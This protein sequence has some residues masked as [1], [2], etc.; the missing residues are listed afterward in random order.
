MVRSDVVRKQLAGV[1]LHDRLGPEGY[2]AEMTARTFAE[3]DRRV[4]EA[5]RIGRPVVADAVFADPSERDRLARIA[6]ACGV[7]FAVLWLEAAPARME[8]RLAA[9]IADVSDATVEVLRRQR[10]YDLGQVEWTRVDSGGTREGTL[11][12]ALALLGLRRPSGAAL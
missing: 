3:L 8:R 6:R 12:K 10:T 2:A 5:L 1:G 7:P 11:A 9:R 4:E